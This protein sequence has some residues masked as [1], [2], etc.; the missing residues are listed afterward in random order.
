MRAIRLAL[1]SVLLATT[2][3]ISVVAQ[4]S[5]PPSR[6]ESDAQRKWVRVFERHASDY[7]VR[8]GTKDDAASRAERT[9]EP[10]LRWSQPVRGG[11][12]GA[13]YLWVRAGRPVAAIT[14]FTFKW[15]DGKRAL[16]HER[17]SLTQEPI[18]AEWRTR[19]MWQT[20]RAGVGYQPVP[21][22]PKPAATAPGRLRQMQAIVREF[23][24]HT[25]DG[26]DKNW[27]LRLLPTPLYRFEGA[28]RNS[29][30]GALFALVQ[31]TDPEAFLLIDARG[32]G[33]AAR[34]EFAVARFTDRK[35]EVQ[36]K[37]RSVYSGHDTVGGANEVYF[38]D[39]VILK[40]GDNPED[41]H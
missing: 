39:T 22:A 1:V 33:D 38:S 34:W 7:I 37:G 8:E 32:A 27:P 24:A 13:L 17:H 2:M 9:A 6:P 20:S 5:A 23:A 31:G 16:V 40:P 18:A 29:L 30:D 14:F 12:D 36:Y 21:E 26:N 10:V 41:F 11:D 19:S 15:P 25:V 28:K 35:L 3:P 4:E